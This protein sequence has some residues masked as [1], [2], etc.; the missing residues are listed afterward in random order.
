ML[1][2][3][4]ASPRLAATAPEL[5]S[6]VPCGTDWSRAKATVAESGV[7]QS[8]EVCVAAAEAALQ[9]GH[10]IGFLQCPHCAAPQVAS[11]APADGMH[12]CSVC[13]H[14]W[15]GPSVAS[16]PLALLQPVLS[17]H[18]EVMF[19]SNREWKVVP[20]SKFAR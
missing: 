17:P 15:S 4:G 9:E 20:A 10:Q 8:V 12:V 6:P 13:T 1:R 14:R 2:L 7:T 19:E 18:G 11:S 5:S 16:N 3:L